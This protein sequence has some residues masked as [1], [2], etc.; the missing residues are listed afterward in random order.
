[1]R[2]RCR[3]RDRPASAA[4]DDDVVDAEIVDEDTDERPM[5]DRDDEQPRVVIRDKR[6]IDPV[7][8]E[9]RVPAGEQPAGTRPR[10][11]RPSRT[12]GA[13]ERA[14]DAG[15]RRAAAGQPAAGGDDLAAGSWPSAPRTCSGSPPSTPTTAGGSTATASLVV[16]Q[17]AERFALQLFPIL[18]DIERARDHGDLTGA[19][20]VVAERVLGLLDGSGV[21]AFGEAGDPFDPSLHEAVIHD[22]SPEV[23]VPTATTVL[24]QGYRRG[25]RVLRTA[26]VAV[27]RPGVARHRPQPAAPTRTTPPP[28]TDRPRPDERGAPDEHPGLH[29]EGLL[30]RAGRPQGRRRRGDQ[31]GLP[32][33]GPRPAPGQEPGQRRGGGRF[34]EVSEAYDVLSDTKRRASTTRRGGCSAPAVAPAASRR[35]VPRGGGGQTFDLGDLFGAAGGRRRPAG[36]GLGDLFGGLFGG[37]GGGGARGRS[38]AA[39]GPA[40]GQDVETEATL[41]FD[42]A[43]LGVTVPLRMQSPGT[44]QTCHGN[45]AKPGHQRRTPARSARAPASPAATRAR[46][47]SPSRAATAAAPARSSTTRARPAAAAASP[48]RPARSP[49]AS[50][51]G[52]RTASASGWPARARRAARRPGRRPVRRRPRRRH[53]LFGRKGDDLTLTVPVTFAEAALGRR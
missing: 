5:S 13:D 19:F 23:S 10:R 6:R 47:R 37:G 52:S 33:A 28:P 9:V 1:M 30:R 4:G 40:R 7:T 3:R 50:R 11:E 36:G 14:R 41:A 53:A 43:V 38:Q 16:D 18:D 25:D 20:K 35:R 49:S 21:E 46:S 32:Q 39:S 24:R 51:P 44:C 27:D 22:T 8:G 29:R 26:M 17:A 2:R 42:E 31:E 34:K 15:G 48:A 12:R 45:G